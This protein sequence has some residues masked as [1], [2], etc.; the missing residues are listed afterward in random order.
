M[1]GTTTSAPTC[2]VYRGGLP[3]ILT[4]GVGWG[5]VCQRWCSCV[6]IV[7][8]WCVD[9]YTWYVGWGGVGCVNVGV[10]VYTWYAAGV[11]MCTHGTLLVCWCVHMVRCWCVHV[12]T[13]YAAGVLMCTH[14]TWG[15]VGWG[16][17]T[18]V[19]MCTRYAAGVLMCTHGTLL[20][21]WCVHMVRC[22]CVHVYTWYAAGVL[23]CTHGTWGGVG[24]GGVCQRWCSCVHMVRCWCV[25]VYTWYAA[26]VLMCT[27]GALLVCSC[28][29]MVRCWCVDVY[30]WYVGWGG[31]GWGVST[32]VFMCTH[33]TLLVCWCVHMVRCW[34]VDVYTWYAAG[35]LMCTHG[36]LLVCSCVHMVRCWCVHV[37]TWYAAGVS[38]ANVSRNRS[39]MFDCPSFPHLDWVQCISSC[40]VSP[41]C[42]TLSVYFWCMWYIY[43]YVYFMSVYICMQIVSNGNAVNYRWLLIFPP[44]LAKKTQV[45]T[46]SK[47]SMI[48]CI[49]QKYEVYLWTTTFYMK[50]HSKINT[51][52][53]RTT[54]GCGYSSHVV[55]VDLVPSRANPPGGANM[56]QSLF[57]K[58][59]QETP[60]V[61][62]NMWLP[63]RLP[64][65]SLRNA[66]LVFS[67]RQLNMGHPS[68]L[69][70][71]TS[72]DQ[73]K[74]GAHFGHW[75]PK[76]WIFPHRMTIIPC[77]FYEHMITTSQPSHY[78]CCGLG[79][80]TPN[81]FI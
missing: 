27:H 32:L 31:V 23:M 38:C 21:C 69:G 65:L 22:W 49:W 56:L 43:M 30:T 29:H 10:H 71:G 20:V 28:L 67:R 63:P 35:V 48:N 18:L 4:C 16:V 6:H 24:W 58:T 40:H 77:H 70:L 46:L 53:T 13:S 26:G 3:G 57:H 36:A 60:L 73:L 19:F 7:R 8:C 33:G 72:C 17:S 15:G 75:H 64:A 14:G 62:G 39:V 42:L 55:T 9:V 78:E 47:H 51:M 37:C 74:D 59:I 76:W 50:K 11:L 44:D 66:Q 61:D 34:C 5:G 52:T 12:Y 54:N 68:R 1:W 2:W 25:D 81:G 79:K 45:W 41:F 80:T